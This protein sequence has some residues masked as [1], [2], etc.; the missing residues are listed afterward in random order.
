MIMFKTNISIFLVV[1]ALFGCGDKQVVEDKRSSEAESNIQAGGQSE[2]KLE[3]QL[4]DIKKEEEARLKL[5]SETKTT[6]KFDRK[7][8]DFGN[9]NQGEDNTTTFIVTN[10]GNKPLIIED[11]A[12]SC[13]CTTP[14][15]PEKPILPGKTDKITVT[16]K[17]KPEQKNEV[18]KTVTVT[19]NTDPIVEKLEIRAFVK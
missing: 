2:K 11:V 12:A 19:A 7:Y 6:M 15:K 9:V 10:T 13:G 3:A 8:H 18:I 1:F 5:D 14:Q 17:A 16:F 4:A